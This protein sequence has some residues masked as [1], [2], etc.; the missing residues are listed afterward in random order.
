MTV[1]FKS[2][3]RVFIALIVLTIVYPFL[4]PEINGQGWGLDPYQ[5]QIAMSVGIN[6]LLAVSLTLINGITGQF[7]IGHA[8]FMAI[9]AYSSGFLS[10]TFAHRFSSAMGG[11][12]LVLTENLWI[13]CVLVCGGSLAAVFGFFVGMPTLR[14]RGDYLA[15]ATLGF[16]EIV[17]VVILNQPHLGGA[18]GLT[19][20]PNNVGIFWIYLMLIVCV[21]LVYRI[22]RSPRGLSFS[23]VREDEI[24]AMSVGINPTRYKVA[25]FIIGAFFAGVAGALFAHQS[26]SG[27]INPSSFGFIKSFELVVMIVLGGLGSI[28][29]AVIGAVVLTVLPEF[30]R[31]GNQ[32]R[33]VIYAAMLIVLMLLR[34]QGLFGRHELSMAGV[35]GFVAGFFRK[36]KGGGQ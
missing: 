6:A 8:A 25:A 34:P 32:Y 35:K 19:V 14:L 21:C 4:T 5:K 3:I 29:G 26:T 9:G 15:I 1:F 30:L 24:A 2:N 7:S 16:G 12:P 33:I 27:Y 13:L 31:M 22:S 20:R 28:T 18:T 36:K 23:A 17:R 10:L 11:L